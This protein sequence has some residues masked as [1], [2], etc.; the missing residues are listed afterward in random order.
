MIFHCSKVVSTHLWNTPLNLYQEAKEFFFFHNWRTGGIAERVWCFR[1]VLKQPFE[2]FVFGD[3]VIIG[4]A[5]SQCF[6]VV[7]GVGKGF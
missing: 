3:V 5:A 4:F 7:L 6:F 2:L 1:G